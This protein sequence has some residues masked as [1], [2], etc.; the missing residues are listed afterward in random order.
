MN[1][2]PVRGTSVVR[3]QALTIGTCVLLA[4]AAFFLWTE[5]RAH[6]LGALP[7]LLLL[8]CSH[9]H[10]FMHRGHRSSHLSHPTTSGD[11]QSDTQR[12]HQHGSHGCC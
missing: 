8:A 2:V 5:H 3:S 11:K 12:E 7:W 4:I 1:L 10:R 9:M 6:L